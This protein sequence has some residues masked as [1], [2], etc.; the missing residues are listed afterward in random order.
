MQ[1]GWVDGLIL[2]STGLQP[3]LILLHQSRARVQ[4][5]T[6][7]GSAIDSLCDLGQVT[8]L[9]WVSVFSSG[10]HLPDGVLL[11][12]KWDAESK[13]IQHITGT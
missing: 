10:K 4:G 13:G 8:P 3:W 9:L 12:V 7:T 1:K 5:L 6:G 11:R 2:G